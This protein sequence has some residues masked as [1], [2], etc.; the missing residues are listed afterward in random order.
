MTYRKRALALRMPRGMSEAAAAEFDKIRE[1]VR[2]CDASDAA[3]TVAHVCKFTSVSRLAVADSDLPVPMSHP[4]GSSTNVILGIAR[5]LSG[6]LRTDGAEYYAFGPRYEW[7]ED[8]KDR[9]PK[10]RIRCYLLM[11]SSFVKVDCVPAGHVCA[12][13]NLEHLQWKTVTLCDQLECM[14]LRGFDFGLQP[15]VKVN[16]EPLLASGESDCLYCSMC[17]E[18]P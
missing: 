14:P 1:A 8:G 16:V 9:V 10:Q 15:L 13:Y 7:K 2:R 4:D 18:N 11:G 5:V 17:H 6:T 3:P 12:V